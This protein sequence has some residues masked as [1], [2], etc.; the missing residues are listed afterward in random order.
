MRKLFVSSAVVGVLAGPALAIDRLVPSQY[1]TIQAAIDAAIQGDAVIVSPGTYPETI[2]FLGKA[3][4]V[5]GTDDQLVIIEPPTG[6]GVVFTSGEGPASRLESL[7]ITGGDNALGGGAVIGVGASPMLYDVSF[8][9]CMG[10]FGGAVAINSGASPHFDLCGFTFCEALFDGGGV[11]CLP[12]SSPTFET[13]V[14]RANDAGGS[15][16]NI[17]IDHSDV[18]LD[19]C[20]F[21]TGSADYGGGI[22]IEGGTLDYIGGSGQGIGD[23]R[24][25]HASVDGGGIHA[26]DG[27]VAT[28]LRA[29]PDDNSALGQGGGVFVTG[30]ASVTM[31]GGR[32]ERNSAVDGAGAC[33]V[34]GEA[35]FVGCEFGSNVAGSLGGG[36]FVFSDS[37]EEISVANVMHSSF[38][39]NL[40]DHG[41]AV[42]ARSTFVLDGIP[43]TTLSLSNSIIAG[44]FTFDAS[45]SAGVEGVDAGA[46]GVQTV[47]DIRSCTIADNSGGVVNGVRG[48]ASPSAPQVNLYNSIVWGNAGAD[49]ANADPARTAT[50]YSIFPAPAAYPGPGN[51]DADPMFASG[52]FAFYHLAPGSP[53]RDAGSNPLAAPDIIDADGDGDVSEPLPVDFDGT[54]AIPRFVNDG[55]TPDTGVGPGD[56]ID[57]GAREAQ[58]GTPCSDADIVV[59]G[60]LDFSDVLAFLNAFD[61]MSPAAD[62]A[63]PFGVFDFS[64]VFAFLTAF[65]AGCP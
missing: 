7:T 62:L 48:L 63:E 53:A 21:D 33:V 31:S 51:F 16:G 32:I 24:Q 26:S 35:T 8:T 65:G 1:P 25:N 43:S 61:A 20:Q 55:G 19:N 58:E 30:G 11:A 37:D 47:M 29:H 6:P 39:G 17:H 9:Q 23:I 4:T 49:F 5:R 36:L 41:A 45:G 22:A 60:E 52:G 50:G 38:E 57:I 40:A 18:I 13:C 34:G 56:I 10:V 42:S 44:N 14:F 46:A 64:D 15:G 59:P 12:G 28:F 54:L 27:A 3:I 2:D